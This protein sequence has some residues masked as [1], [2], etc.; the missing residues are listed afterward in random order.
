MIQ[1]DTR[2]RREFN[3]FATTLNSGTK[4][5]EN[6]VN[7]L[8]AGIEELRTGGITSFNEAAKAFP[9]TINNTNAA[10]D[11]IEEGA[12][13]FQETVREFEVLVEGLQKHWLVAQE[14]RGPA[15]GYPRKPETKD[16][17]FKTGVKPGG[18]EGG[19]LKKLFNKNAE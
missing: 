17:A 10:I 9:G 3:E 11:Q 4:S 2:M 18:G 19:L 1:S 15:R 14:H 6:A 12:R 7:N 5:L 8:G 16:L 13:Q